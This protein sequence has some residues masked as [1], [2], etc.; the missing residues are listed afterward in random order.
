MMDT[1]KA[2]QNI[3]MFLWNAVHEKV[4]IYAIKPGTAEQQGKVPVVFP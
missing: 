4:T 3:E 1:R 2:I